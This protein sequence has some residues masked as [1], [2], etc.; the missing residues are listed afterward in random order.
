MKYSTKTNKYTLYDRLVLYITQNSTARHPHDF[1]IALTPQM[2]TIITNGKANLQS[3]H[4]KPE[5]THRRFRSSSNVWGMCQHIH[6]C[7]FFAVRMLHRPDTDRMNTNAYA[8][9]RSA[10]VAR[11]RTDMFGVRWLILLLLLCPVIHCTQNLTSRPH[12]LTMADSG[13][14]MDYVLDTYADAW[15]QL[16]AELFMDFGHTYVQLFTGFFVSY[17]HQMQHNA[18]VLTSAVGNGGDVPALVRQ[19]WPL[20][21]DLWAGLRMVLSEIERQ[22]EAFLHSFANSLRDSLGPIALANRTSSCQSLDDL[23]SAIRSADVG[24]ERN[25][26]R[27]RAKYMRPLRKHLNGMQSLHRQE[28]AVIG[29]PDGHSSLRSRFAESIE[30]SHKELDTVL[31]AYWGE[32]IKVFLGNWKLYSKALMTVLKEM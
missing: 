1:Y 21:V 23:H 13:L 11:T 28:A 20:G 10:F 9:V 12:E 27:C 31:Q 25:Y 15:R 14:D 26:V 2:T 30:Q 29:A 3:V 22:L 7:L 4:K 17:R 8:F 6:N 32:S 18:D 5:Y 16:A 24:Y 19:L